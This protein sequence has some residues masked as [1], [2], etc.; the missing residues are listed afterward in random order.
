MPG[1]TGTR[2]KNSFSW[3]ELSVH[4]GAGCCL[5]DGEEKKTLGETVKGGVGRKTGGGRSRCSRGRVLGFLTPEL[6]PQ[7][8]CAGN[9]KARRRLTLHWFALLGLRKLPWMCGSSASSAGAGVDAEMRQPSLWG[10]ALKALG[11]D[12]V[13]LER[14]EGGG[15]SSGEHSV[16][17]V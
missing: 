9:G 5:G 2:E 16:M 13:V 12:D 6:G 14:E 8:A 7:G 4:L 1:G 3:R 11:L 10:E 17:G 15:H